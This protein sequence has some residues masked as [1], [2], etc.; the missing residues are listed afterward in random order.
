MFITSKDLDKD[1]ITP[2]DVTDTKIEIDHDSNLTKTSS[3]NKGYK[4]YLY[5]INDLTFKKKNK[6]IIGI[7]EFDDMI[8]SQKTINSNHGM[9]TLN[10]LQMA[11]PKYVVKENAL[12]GQVISNKVGETIID[13]T[14][15]GQKGI[16]ILQGVP[17]TQGAYSLAPA[18]LEILKTIK[19][20]SDVIT[21]ETS[22]K[23]LSGYAIAQLS[24]QSQKPIAL[25]Q[26]ELWR[27]KEREAEI[28]RQFI[29]LFY[30]EKTEYKYPT[31]ALEKERMVMIGQ[32]PM[33]FNKD[34]FS[35]EEFENFEFDVQIEVGAGTQYSEIQTMSQLDGLLQGQY[36]DFMTYIECYP[37][38]AMPCKRQL[39]EMI[40][41]REMSENTQ[42]KQQI[43][44]LTAQLE[45]LAN[46]SSSLES[47][48]KDYKRV[49]AESQRLVKQLT[50]EYTNKINQANK[51]IEEQAGSKND[52]SATNK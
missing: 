22:S 20:A 19:G 41:A 5:P 14:P 29:I 32:D 31:T 11:C 6:S 47:E 51:I 15:A 45:Q 28:F 35:G 42:L 2:D 52:N 46:Y 17:I 21:G 9:A 7:P 48:N 4:A 23:D 44:E 12:Q 25:L 49:V 1:N 24:A 38:K 39:K 34:T 26:K 16:D 10:N 13:Y 33:E 43:Q 30:N 36:I 8:E 18:T 40:R 27:H 50:Q 37:E 3:S